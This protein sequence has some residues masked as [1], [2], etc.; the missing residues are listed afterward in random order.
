MIEHFRVPS[1]KDFQQWFAAVL[2]TV[3]VLAPIIMYAIGRDVP[4]EVWSGVTFAVGVWLDPP[5][6]SQKS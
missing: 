4:G 2:T 5:S 6:M 1:P 3:I